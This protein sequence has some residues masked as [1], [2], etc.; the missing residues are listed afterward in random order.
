MTSNLAVNADRIAA[1]IEA[2][3]AITEPDR[4]WTR[5]A[6]TPMFLKGRAY[7]EKIFREAGLETHIDAAGNMTGRRRGTVEGKGT[8]MLGSHTDTV[9]NGGRFDGIAGVLVGLEVARSLKDA[10]IALEHDLEIVDF[11]AEEVSIFGVSC[12]GSRGMTGVRPPEWLERSTDGVTLA[13]GIRQVGGDPDAVFT[14]T[15]IKAFFELHIEQGTVLERENVDI[16]I[17]GA[18]TGISRFEIL[19]EGRADHAGTTPMNARYDALGA[20]SIIVLG[21]E[22]IARKLAS[23]KSYF[24]GTVGEFSM[25]PNAAN[26]IPSHVRM[27]I[28]ARAVDDTVM[29]EFVASVTALCAQT[30]S[31]RSVTI[32]DP[33]R[34][35]HAAPTP[36]SDMV[37][38]VLA[39]SAQRIGATSRPMVSGAGHDAAFLSK[40]APA[41]MIFIASKDGRSHAAEEWSDNDDIALGAAVLYEA[42]LALD[43]Q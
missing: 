4:P 12:I 16:G 11:L 25:E 3:A 37:T 42:V 21:I 30:A 31:E 36:M 32:A 24:A 10:G 13:D 33:R 9:P 2:L 22:E 40:V 35:S 15:D 19:V 38:G 43:K 23:G 27:L 14:R 7:V 18:I 34:V 8:I 26:V 1:D 28:D 5:R 6:F 20:A 41:A 17:V 39:E 29:D